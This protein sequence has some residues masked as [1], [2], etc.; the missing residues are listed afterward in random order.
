MSIEVEPG[1][2]TC[3]LLKSDSGRPCIW[4][5][6]HHAW[7]AVAR[8]PGASRGGCQ[9]LFAA[10]AFAKN[11]TGEYIYAGKIE[12]DLFGYTIVNPNDSKNNPGGIIDW[13]VDE[14]AKAFGIRPDEV[15]SIDSLPDA[16]LEVEFD[17]KIQGYTTRAGKTGK[18]VDCIA[19][20]GAIGRRFERTEPTSTTK[21]LFSKFATQVRATHPVTAPATPAPAPAPAPALP[22]RTPSP[23]PAPVK[24]EAPAKKTWDAAALWQAWMEEHGNDTAGY[25]AAIDAALGRQGVEPSGLTPEECQQLAYALNFDAPF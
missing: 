8:R 1:I 9:V 21:A 25:F 7:D 15:F 19:A 17:V 20:V 12:C 4:L 16:K 10:E 11:E 3:R 2:Y 24:T 5:D 6:E 13:K 23:A 18:G 14:L 22:T